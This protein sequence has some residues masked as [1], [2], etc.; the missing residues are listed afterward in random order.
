MGISG[1]LYTNGRLSVKTRTVSINTSLDDDY[2][3]NVNAGGGGVTVTLPDLTDSTYDGVTYMI[4][5]QSA[6]TVTLDTATVGDK[7]I[8]DGV[9][10]NSVDLDGGIN[11][12]I[13]VVS[14]GVKWFT[15]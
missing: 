1:S 2:I 4:I 14:N 9:E 3:L 6:N 13:I 8:I 7:I 15:I 10:E 5:K 11:E 12:R